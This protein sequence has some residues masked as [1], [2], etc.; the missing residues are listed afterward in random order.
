MIPICNSSHS[1]RLSSISTTSALF[2]RDTQFEAIAQGFHVRIRTLQQFESIR[3]HTHRPCIDQGSLSSLE[4]EVEVSRMPWI[5][6]EGVYRTLRIGFGVCSQ[7]FLCKLSSE[8]REGIRL[9]LSYLYQ[10]CCQ[11][12]TSHAASIRPLSWPWL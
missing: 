9:C 2:T 12:D 7:P 6:A 10:P 8:S 1:H 11:I 4:A 3:H 5:Q